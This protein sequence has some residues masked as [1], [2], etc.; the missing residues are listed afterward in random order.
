MLSAAF[1]LGR[2]AIYSSYLGSG[3]LIA[4]LNPTFNWTLLRHPPG[5]VK[6]ALFNDMGFYGVA[7]SAQDQVVSGVVLKWWPHDNLA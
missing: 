1:A 2:L 5:L 4:P 7:S 6:Q 3:G